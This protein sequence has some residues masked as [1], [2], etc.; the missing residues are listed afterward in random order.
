M[1]AALNSKTRA[2][3][4]VAKLVGIFFAPSNKPRLFVF[5]AKKPHFEGKIHAQIFTNSPK[6]MTEKTD[7]QSFPNVVKWAL[8]L[9]FSMFV[10]EIG[11][12]FYSN[13]LALIFDATDFLGD[14]LNYAIAIY[15]LAKPKKFQSLAAIIKAAFMLSFGIYVLANGI[16]RISMD[17]LPMANIMIE[18]S[19][20]AFVVNF[21]VSAMLFRFRNGN[22]NQQSVWL[23]S[24]ND[25]INNA[26][27]IFAGAAVG[28][29]QSKWPD[30]LVAAVMAILAISAAIA[31]L[32]QV[33]KEM[34]EE[35]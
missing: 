19:I 25:A 30:L 16:Y 10:I 11:F 35:N 28:Y 33:R 13:S 3:F 22:S 21:L 15:V 26:M 17:A 5:R 9:N 2:A 31:V 7:Q 29:Y 14:S 4:Q 1:K 12:G 6:S 20:L 23:C 8:V 32:R 24:R 34:R 18:V 27:T